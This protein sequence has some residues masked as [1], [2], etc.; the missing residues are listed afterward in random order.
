M[1]YHHEGIKEER[2]PEKKYIYCFCTNIAVA[3]FKDGDGNWF[4]GECGRVR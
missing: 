1:V 4:C 3:H 2:K